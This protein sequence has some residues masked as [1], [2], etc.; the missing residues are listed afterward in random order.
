MVRQQNM[1]MKKLMNLIDSRIK[2]YEKNRTELVVNL[3]MSH[4]VRGPLMQYPPGGKK[5]LRQAIH[6][7]IAELEGMTKGLR[8]LRDFLFA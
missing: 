4:G 7:Q 1:S 5:G 6:R 2:E 3:N 8:D